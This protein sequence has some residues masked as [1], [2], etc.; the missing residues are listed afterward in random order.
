MTTK[1]PRKG[2]AS[3]RFVG[4]ADLQALVLARM[5]MKP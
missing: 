5:V 2:V 1:A 4:T 3:I